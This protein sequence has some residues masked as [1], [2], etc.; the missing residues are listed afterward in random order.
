MALKQF[1]FLVRVLV[2]KG[3][4]LENYDILLFP[5][6]LPVCQGLFEEASFLKAS[7]LRLEFDF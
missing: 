7:E 5:N 3:K 6:S 2:A 4:V 1:Y